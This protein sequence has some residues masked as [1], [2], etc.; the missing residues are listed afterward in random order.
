MSEALRAVRSALGTDALIMETKNL[1]QDQ[2]GGV[3]ITALAEGA[4][5]KENLEPVAMPLPR[6]THHPIDD[7]REEVSTLK[8]MLG[9]LAPG[10]AHKDKIVQTLVKHGVAPEIITQLGEAARHDIAGDDRERWYRAIA[11]AVPTGGAIGDEP[12][13]VALLGPAGVG[14]TASI[15]KLTICETH[16]QARKVGWINLDQ[17]SLAAGDPLSVYSSILGAQYEKAANRKELQQALER[18]RDCDL[19]LI[20]TPGVNPRDNGAIKEIIRLFQTAPD[21]RRLL[22]L[23]AATNGADLSEWVRSFSQ[24]G[25]HGL[26]FTKLDECRYFGALLNTILA[27]ALPVAYLSLGQNFAGDIE[28]AKAEVFASLLLSG[29]GFDA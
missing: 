12:A 17:R 1:A 18:L 16:R 15:I 11:A 24:V 4:A 27:A 7:L 8:S 22:L 13:R 2:G 6:A 14:K 5:T 21:V 9:W 19:V 28:L 20:D 29:E 3:E 25:L 23:N 10:L 26:F